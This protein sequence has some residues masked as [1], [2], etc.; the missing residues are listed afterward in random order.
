M[1]GVQP[2]VGDDTVQ[3][4]A[5]LCSITYSDWLCVSPL[6]P[7]VNKAVKRE[8]TE[9]ASQSNYRILKRSEQCSTEGKNYGIYGALKFL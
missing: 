8:R 5:D 6:F 3:D 2:S 9:M 1:P 4:G 7:R